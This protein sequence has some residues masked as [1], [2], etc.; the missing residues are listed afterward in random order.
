MDWENTR[1][2]VT[3]GAGFLG[4]AVVAK[5]AE[6]GAIHVTVPR[7]A[8]YDLRQ[9]ERVL[10]LLADAKPDVII[11]MAAVVGGIGA[12]REHPA[13]FFYDNLM[14]GT[15]LMHEAW[16]AGVQKFVTIGTVCAYPKFTPTPFKEEDLWIGTRKRPTPRMD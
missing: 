13:E 4:R 2:V 5:L 12:N 11:H 6:R 7:S 8:Q 10:A 1:F 15:Q 9:H 3:G 16:R 14:M